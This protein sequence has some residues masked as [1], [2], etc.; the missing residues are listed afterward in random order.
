MIHIS[1][2]NS[3]VGHIPSFSLTPGE[4]CSATACTT[5]YKEGCYARKICRIRPTV[6]NAYEENT[7]IVRENLPFF[8][9]Y[10]NAYFDSVAAPRYFR[11]HVSGDFFSREYAEAWADIARNHPFTNF[12]AFTKQFDIIRSVDFPDN[13]KIVLSAWPGT[14]IPADLRSKYHVAWMDNGDTFIP[15]DAQECAGNCE[16]CGNCWNLDHDV[17]FHKH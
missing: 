12:L 5:C 17:V 2:K 4:T 8:Q 14:E 10:M 13:F 15:P 16:L 11:V 9:S 1:L 7:A 3:K 6:R